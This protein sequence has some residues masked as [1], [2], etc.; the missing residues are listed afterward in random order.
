MIQKKDQAEKLRRWFQ[1]SKI[2]V[3]AAESLMPP[4]ESSPLFMKEKA[5]ALK[6]P[7]TGIL[8]AV[9]VI[10]VVIL[11]AVKAYN[12]SHELSRL[13][14]QQM[15]NSVSALS[16]TVQSLESALQ[17]TAAQTS[18]L[19]QEISYIRRENEQLKK[20]VDQT[21]GE[22]ETLTGDLK[23]AQEKIA[24]LE[25]SR[26]ATQDETAR[27]MGVL[28][29]TVGNLNA[30]IEAQAQH[31]EESRFAPKAQVVQVNSQY[32][33]VVINQG[34]QQGV[35]EGNEFDVRR[36]DSVLGRIKV[37][38]ARKNVSAAQIV[39]GAGAIEKGDEVVLP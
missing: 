19:S 33:F 13:K 9:I 25:Q 29:R 23:D 1:R 4:Q 7:F 6:G 30:Q 21:T 12:T 38:Q 3:P 16:Q 2:S 17:N 15:Q 24:V 28:R 27:Q 32:G 34:A 37:L 10:T 20:D 18:V 11:S 14:E 22:R 39:S 35:N 5:S 8:F 26:Q 31:A 36:S